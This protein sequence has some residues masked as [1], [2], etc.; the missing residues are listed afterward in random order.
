MAVN[1]LIRRSIREAGLTH[2]EVAR[3]L[4]FGQQAFSDRMTGR[5]PWRFDEV[6]ALV[7]ELQIDLGDFINACYQTAASADVTTPAALAAPTVGS[8]A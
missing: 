7:C 6:I 8:P 3:A 4:G 1:D 2:G 5:T